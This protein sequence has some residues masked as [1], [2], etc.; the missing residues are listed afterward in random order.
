MP[1]DL[2]FIEVESMRDIA[3]VRRASALNERIDALSSLASICRI[4][5]QAGITLLRISPLRTR[6][7]TE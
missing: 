7:I 2:V 3:V 5:V 4:G 1:G 6:P